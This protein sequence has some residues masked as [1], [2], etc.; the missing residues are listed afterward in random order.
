M[1]LFLVFPVAVPERS[2]FCPI[3]CKLKSH[4]LGRCDSCKG[5][6]K[7]NVWLSYEDNEWHGVGTLILQLLEL[8]MEISLEDTHTNKKRRMPFDKRTDD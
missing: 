4:D 7:Q 1:W 6:G 8:E 5:A 2:P 3:L